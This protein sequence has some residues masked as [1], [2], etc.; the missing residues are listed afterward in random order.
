MVYK[1]LGTKLI[2]YMPNDSL[3]AFFETDIITCTN[4]EHLNSILLQK[5]NEC[6]GLS[7]FSF[8]DSQHVKW[9]YHN[10]KLETTS[11]P[12]FYYCHKAFNYKH[13]NNRDVGV[14]SPFCMG[15]S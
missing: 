5:F 13:T 1:S 9:L 12:D 8:F 7:N 14:I 6:L 15:M 2:N 3:P 11:S 10:K 4:E